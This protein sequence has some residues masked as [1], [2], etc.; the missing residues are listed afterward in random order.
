M[1]AAGRDEIPF[2]RGSQGTLCL[3]M[4]VLM[5]TPHVVPTGNDGQVEV[6]VDLGNL[7]PGVEFAAGEAWSF[8]LW[9]RDLNPGVATNTSNAVEVLFCR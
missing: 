8:Q 1:I 4:P 3:E 9:Y 6:E 2:F 7:P 5:F